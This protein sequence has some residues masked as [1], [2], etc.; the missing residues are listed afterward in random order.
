[1]KETSLSF[2]T[3]LRT[4]EEVELLNTIFLHLPS[5]PLLLWGSWLETTSHQST[6][7][8][9]VNTWSL[10]S[11]LSKQKKA[12]ASPDAAQPF[13]LG[14][15][16]IFQFL[17]LLQ[18]LWSWKRPSRKMLIW[19]F[20]ASAQQPVTV[21]SQSKLHLFKWKLTFQSEMTTQA[22]STHFTWHQGKYW[23]LSQTLSK[24]NSEKSPGALVSWSEEKSYFFQLSLGN[25]TQNPMFSSPR[26]CV[27]LIHNRRIIF[28]FLRLES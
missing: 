4:E 26:I 13:Y 28:I 19:E 27:Q 1:M 7:S 8:S 18:A 2:E 17:H 10:Q 25:I 11:G 14:Q 16:L 3:L 6:H 23:A 24:L 21:Y 9:S 12:M 22:Q 20:Q 5:E 15:V